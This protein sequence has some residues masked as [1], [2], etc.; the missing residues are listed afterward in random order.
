MHDPTATTWKNLKG[1][2]YDL[3]LTTNGS[4]NAEGRALVVNGVS[5]AGATAAPAYK[6]IE[7][8]FKR[9]NTGGRILFNSGIKSRFVLFDGTT[10]FAAYFTGVNPTKRIYQPS[11]ASEINFLAARYDDDN[12]V[13]DVSRGFLVPLH[14]LP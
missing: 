9:T 4:W 6:T 11:V 13:S 2:G 10:S 12:N 8:V 1:G 14:F 3:T 7:V 5:A